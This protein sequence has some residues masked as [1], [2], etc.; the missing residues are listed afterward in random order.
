MINMNVMAMK[1]KAIAFPFTIGYYEY[2][3]VKPIIKAVEKKRHTL[4]PLKHEPK[5]KTYHKT[6]VEV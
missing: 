2:K 4:K 5:K 6:I 1:V 3:L